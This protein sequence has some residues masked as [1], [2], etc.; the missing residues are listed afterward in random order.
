MTSCRPCH[1]DRGLAPDP[2]YVQQNCRL[3]VEGCV[4]VGFLVSVA[5]RCDVPQENPRAVGRADYGNAG[6][7]AA[8]V[9][10]FFHPYEDLPPG[11][12]DATP[13]QVDRRAPDPLG[14]ILY[15]E[16]I[17]PKVLLR[18]FNTYLQGADPIQFHLGDIGVGE[19]LIPGLLPQFPE[20]SLACPAVKDEIDDVALSGDHGDFRVLGVRRESGD[21]VHFALYVLGQPLKVLPFEKF[22]AYGT[23]A[24]PG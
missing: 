17:A 10:P 22:H 6:E 1:L 15:G 11:G 16:I 7:L 19:E 5:H 20:G 24:L 2:V 13:R 3:V 9:A 14:D 4:A 21:A 8:E 12:F 18:N 23:T